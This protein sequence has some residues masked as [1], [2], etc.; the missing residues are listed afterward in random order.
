MTH[1]T[2]T[3]PNLASLKA[4]LDRLLH[5]SI[6]HYIGHPDKDT[7]PQ[8]FRDRHF[9]MSDI[10]VLADRIYAYKEC[11]LAFWDSNDKEHKVCISNEFYEDG[12]RAEILKSIEPETHHAPVHIRL[13]SSSDID[14]K[15][16]GQSLMAE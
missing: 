1:E 6:I 3:L 8:Q 9:N 12:I 7:A 13:T 4:W 2:L 14:L 11:S 16:I 10:D 5:I 15:N